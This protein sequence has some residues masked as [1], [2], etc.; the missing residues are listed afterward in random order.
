[1]HEPLAG[2]IP[3]ALD[4]TEET[5]RKAYLDGLRGCAACVVLFAHILI[6][7]HSH[8]N[9][10]FNGNAA[11]CVFFVLSGY[12][13]TDL[14][15]RS[16]LS[17]PAQALRRYVRLVAPMLVTSSFAWALLAA[18]LYRNREAAAALDSW[19]LARWYQFEPSFGG[20]VV[21]TLYGVFVSGQSI[22]NCNLW[23]MRP[24]LIGSLYIFV[25]NATAPARGLR[26]ICYVAL[27]LFYWAD[28]LALF[29]AGALL[30]EFQPEI[31]SA[32]S[33]L[34]GNVP[35]LPA[36]S[37]AVGLFL[38][39]IITTESEF[40]GWVFGWLPRLAAA[41]QDNDMHWH[42]LGASIVVATTL[43]WPL[44]Q[45]VFG[46]RL[47]RF[48]GKISFVLYLVHVPIICSFMAWAFLAFG[49][50][51]AALST[52]VLVFV[53]SAAT[54]RIIDE[55]PTRF[56]RQAGRAVDA[57]FPPAS[58]R[59]T[60]R[61]D[62]DNRPDRQHEQHQVEAHLG[63]FHHPSAS[64]SSRLGTPTRSSV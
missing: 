20:M 14:S 49:A 45:G 38:S 4:A 34:R 24:E 35:A 55:M 56:S 11:V 15:R 48:L 43:H 28:Y 23:T 16:G 57:L 27:A 29:P 12:V 9:A 7:L 8:L 47:G 13:L 26:T 62:V 21:E 6:A 41:A 10:L 32:V 44:A 18:G 42:M 25:I 19:W 58:L 36:V 54:Y 40:T 50:T 17:F 53:I 22:Y 52:V 5:S 2:P 60:V 63:S 1:M 51:I 59:R 39:M 31:A 3:G 61:D 33:K 64:S 30:C 46:S 37:F